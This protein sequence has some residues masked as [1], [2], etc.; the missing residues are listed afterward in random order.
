MNP[1]ELVARYMSAWNQTDGDARRRLL[2]AT[3]ASDGAYSDPTAHVAGRDA[4]V[5]HIEPFHREV[6]AD[7][8]TLQWIIGFFGPVEPKSPTR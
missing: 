5:E 6:A 4:F 1:V 3:W 8:T 2:E 7:G